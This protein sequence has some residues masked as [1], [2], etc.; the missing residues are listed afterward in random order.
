[1]IKSEEEILQSCNANLLLYRF[2][3]VFFFGFSDV[4][5]VPVASPAICADNISVWLPL[6]NQ[7]SHEEVNRLCINRRQE[8]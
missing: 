3:R 5:A 2:L 7:V 8:V 6:E 4:I 1:M